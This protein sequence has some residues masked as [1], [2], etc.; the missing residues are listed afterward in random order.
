MYLLL[1]ACLRDFHKVRLPVV[2]CLATCSYHNHTF[3]D[4]HDV[5]ATSEA[6]NEQHE[7]TLLTHLSWTSFSLIFKQ[8]LYKIDGDS[9]SLLISIITSSAIK[10]AT[11]LSICTFIFKNAS[12]LDAR[13]SAS[14]NVSS[15][16]KTRSSKE[17][18]PALYFCYL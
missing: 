11:I 1:L 8:I 13:T 16:R 2:S 15:F 3:S 17:L 5:G 7:N 10:K 6:P 4:Q 18:G 9:S 14:L 12:D